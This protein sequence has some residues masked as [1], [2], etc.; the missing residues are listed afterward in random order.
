MQAQIY[1]ELG[2]HAQALVNY[3]ALYAL[4]PKSVNQIPEE[5]LKDVSKKDY[6]ALM[7]QKE[8]ARKQAMEDYKKSHKDLPQGAKKVI[9]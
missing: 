6:D 3:Q 7:K 2:D 9:M 1:D 8:Q 5:Y 4:E